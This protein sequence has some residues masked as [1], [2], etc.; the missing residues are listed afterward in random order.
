MPPLAR[1][2]AFLRAPAT[3]SA[4]LHSFGCVRLLLCDRHASFGGA[5]FRPR[6][7]CPLQV[8]R[9]AGPCPPS[10]SQLRSLTLTQT[11][12][13]PCYCLLS[14]PRWPSSHHLHLPPPPKRVVASGA[15]LLMHPCKITFSCRFHVSRVVQVHRAYFSDDSV[16]RSICCMTPAAHRSGERRD[17]KFRAVVKISG[18]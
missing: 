2:C 11:S 7:H 8:V 10:L 18:R 5:W 15:A 6:G 17:M 1:D 16:G 3:F 13:L 14:P 9:S 4:F 12:W